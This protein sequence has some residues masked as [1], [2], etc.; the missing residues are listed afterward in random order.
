M[1]K[2]LKNFKEVSLEHGKFGILCSKVNTT[3]CHEIDEECLYRLLYSMHT[4]GVVYNVRY[5][6]LEDLSLTTQAFVENYLSEELRKSPEVQQVLN[7]WLKHLE[8]NSIDGN[9]VMSLC[10]CVSND[11]DKFVYTRYNDYTIDG[12]ID[13]N[14]LK[15]MLLDIPQV[16]EYIKEQ[17]SLRL[18][19]MQQRLKEFKDAAKNA[20]TVDNKAFSNDAKRKQFVSK[21]VSTYPELEEHIA[22]LMFY[23]TNEVGK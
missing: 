17:D 12:Q 20:H 10:I 19:L 13:W 6:E 11:Y 8:D 23:V 2:F 21:Y 9:V 4:K 16:M 1:V 14:V 22:D 5:Q 3:G 7:T 18:A 15:Q